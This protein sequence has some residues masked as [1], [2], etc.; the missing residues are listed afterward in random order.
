MRV[1]SVYPSRSFCTSCSFVLLHDT[2]LPIAV[3]LPYLIFQ[4]GLSMNSPSRRC[5]YTTFSILLVLSRFFPTYIALTTA[6]S[7]WVQVHW[8]TLNAGCS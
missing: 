3:V 1:S 7:L 4:H 2:L 8:L 5:I 6:C